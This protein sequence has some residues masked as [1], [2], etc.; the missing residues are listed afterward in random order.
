MQLKGSHPRLSFLLLFLFPLVLLSFYNVRTSAFVQYQIY[1]LY[2]AGTYQLDGS[3][4]PSYFWN[5]EGLT[6]SPAQDS[7]YFSAEVF[8]TH[9]IPRYRTLLRY[10]LKERSTYKVGG[11][12]M[13]DLV[14]MAVQPGNERTLFTIHVPPEGSCPSLECASVRMY[15]TSIYSSAG[16]TIVNNWNIKHP[17]LAVS[18]GGSTLYFP[19]E[20]ISPTLNASFIARVNVFGGTVDPYFADIYPA[21]IGALALDSSRGLLYVFSPSYEALYVVNTTSN[22][23]RYLRPLGSEFYQHVA[24]GLALD[25]INNILYLNMDTIQSRGNWQELWA[26]D[27]SHEDVTSEAAY[28]FILQLAPGGS[29]ENTLALSQ[30]N[31]LLYFL[32]ETYNQV[33]SA[34]LSRT[35]FDMGTELVSIVS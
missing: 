2:G 35:C 7:L 1:P 16:V 9:A 32:E 4:S 34:S 14:F 6:L 15:N 5:P 21:T 19:Y 12:D 25:S 33:S 29:N 26:L 20:Y 3:T 22:E 18:S 24:S 10:D 17:S 27:L 11:I 31:N 28:T 13:T 8:L 30:N 23:K